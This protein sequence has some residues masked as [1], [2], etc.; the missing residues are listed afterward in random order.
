M[1]L[2]GRAHVQAGRIL[3]TCDR[4]GGAAR[5]CEESSSVHLS[6]D[7]RKAAHH[8]VVIDSAGT[9]RLS[10]KTVNDETELTGLIDDVVGLADG[11]EV[12]WAI[13]LNGG[14]AVENLCRP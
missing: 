4:R 6:A 1:H 7:A 2:T 9:R 14:R 11:G 13:D 5:G 3:R 12:T 8:C 10:R